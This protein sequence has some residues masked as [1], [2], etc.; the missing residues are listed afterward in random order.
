MSRQI[1]DE[2]GHSLLLDGAAQ[3]TKL[4]SSMNTR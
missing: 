3:N 4:Y 2:V 1:N